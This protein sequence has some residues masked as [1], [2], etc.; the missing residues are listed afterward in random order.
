MINR[1]KEYHEEPE[2]RPP[3]DDFYVVAYEY[4]EFYVTREVANRVL[5]ELEARKPP[6][7][8]RFTDIYGSVVSVRSQRID[9]VREWTVAQRASA[10]A[11][12]RARRQEEKA[13][14]RPWE[15]DD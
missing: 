7:W 1:L 11:F 12:R 8:I 4:D 5:R 13:D 6:R 3:E 9:H 2:E 15:D 14:R 10:R